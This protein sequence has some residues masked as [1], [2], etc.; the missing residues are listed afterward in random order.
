MSGRPPRPTGRSTAIDVNAPF[1]RL[2][3]AHIFSVGG[4]ALVAMALAGS[5]FFSVDP[6][7]ARWR[8]FGYLV[9]TM[10]PFAVVGPLV[11]PAMDRARGGRR[12]MLLVSTWGRVLVAVL[13]VGS[14]SSES[15]LLF[16]EAFLMLILAKAYQV[17]KA[18]IVPTVTE[19]DAALVEANSKLQLLSGLGGFAMGLPGLLLLLIGPSAVMV[20]AALTFVAAG[21]ASLR[22]PATTVAAE[23]AG[24]DEVAELR[25]GAVVSA[26]SAMATLRA[27]V[28]FVTFLMAFAL[29]GDD[30]ISRPGEVLGRVSAAA[31]DH[32]PVTV[33]DLAPAGAPPTWHFGVIV[34]VSVAGGL[35]GAAIAPVMRK[36]F[37]E[38]FVLLASLAVAA[39]AGGA[40]LLFGGLFGQALLAS[41][42]ALAA[43]AG[44]QAFDAVVQ[45]DAPDANRGRTFSRFESRFQIAW[46][47]GALAPVIIPMPT[48]LGGLIVGV[49]AVAAGAFYATG[50][51][52]V[53]KGQV[54]PRLPTAR[55]AATEVNRWR[56]NRKQRPPGDGPPPAPPAP[57]PASPPPGGGPPPP[58]PPPAGPPPR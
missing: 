44:K 6:A 26:G 49:L 32:D 2:A 28:G 9:F 23:E 37:R 57:P 53:A 13:M 46:V 42:V 5:L 35:G 34:A 1:G 25:S 50:M 15:L 51:R 18:A 33:A 47:L 19:G 14:V 38:E 8:I 24:E 58:A 39:C 54:P 41:G 20:L 40:G 29:R 3:L 52:A 10:A 11:G 55:E 12:I 45:R 27:I 17:A 43:A 4:D 56:R 16:P 22:V 7:G 21:L 36:I 48:P 30:R 31:L